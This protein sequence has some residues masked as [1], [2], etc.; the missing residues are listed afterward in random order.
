[1]AYSAEEFEVK[2]RE[3]ATQLE[4]QAIDI[5]T[6]SIMDLL[7]TLHYAAVIARIDTWF[8]WTSAEMPDGFPWRADELR[9]H[10][11]AQGHAD[12]TAD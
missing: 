1:M 7:A 2:V 6:S 11:A 4:G 8:T 5:A 3:R 10:L 12:D 9:R